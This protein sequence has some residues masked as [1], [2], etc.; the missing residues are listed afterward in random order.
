[1]AEVRETD[2]PAPPPE[3]PKRARVGLWTVLGT[4]IIFS[5]VVLTGLSLTGRTLI[6]PDWVR[7]EIETRINA[8][9]PQG[10]VR[11]GAVELAVSPQG[12]AEVVLRDIAVG[13][14]TGARLADLNAVRT[15]LPLAGL[16]Q[17]DVTP[18]AIALRGAQITV[19]R[20]VE[21]QF[22]LSYG[23]GAAPA[24]RDLAGI[25]DALEATLA[26]PSL[27]EI[28]EFGA[29]DL[30]ITLEDARTGQLWQA[31]NAALRLGRNPDGLSI[32]V[33]SEL[34]NGTD[35]LAELQFSVRSFTETSAADL[36]VQVRDVAAADI[37]AQAPA[38]TYLS[39]LDA[40]VSGSIR[41][42][43]DADGMLDTFAA[44]LEIG[45]G[46]LRPDADAAA[47]PFDAGRA[48][49]TYAPAEQRITFSE[50]SFRS[51]TLAV[52]AEGHALLGEFDGPWPA[53]LTGQ[54][55]LQDMRL[56][57]EG[58]FDAPVSVEDASADF[59]LR[60]DPFGVELG[61]LTARVG[62]GL[63]TATG[64]AG[65][66]GGGWD[67]ALDA[68]I[69]RVDQAAVLA[70]WPVTLTPETRGWLKRNLSQGTLSNVEGAVRVADTAP[71]IFGLSFDFEGAALRYLP[72]MPILEGAA[73][74]ASFHDKRF[75]ISVTDGFTQ[76]RQGR[77][78]IG[79]S[80]FTIPDSD[81]TPS[82]IELDVAAKGAA[83]AALDL[84]SN[85]PIGIL[86][87]LPFGPGDIAGGIDAT[88]SLSLLSG[89]DPTFEELGLSAT[90]R[91][92]DVESAAVAPG[93][94]LASDVLDLTVDADGLVID[95][96]LT[97]DGVPARATLRRSLGPGTQTAAARIDGDVTVTPETLGALSVDL[98]DGTVSGRTQA[99]FEI[100]LPQAGP[101][102]MRVASDLVGLGLAIPPA[103]WAKPDPVRGAFEAIVTLEEA[104][105]ITAL[106]LSAPGLSA[107]NI[108]LSLTED[109]DLASVTIPR[110]RLEDWLD[111]SVTVTPRGPGQIPAL[112]IDGG[113]LDIRGLASQ[114]GTGGA[115]NGAGPVVLNPDRVVISDGITL[116]DFSGQ[117][118]PGSGISGQ[119]TAR[120]NG[121]TAIQG[122]VIP[123][124]N[125]TAIRIQ[126]GDAGGAIRDAGFLKNGAGG[127]LDLIL[128]PNGSPGSYDGEM[129]MENVT[130]RDAPALAALLDGISI[131][132]LLDD[133]GT[134]I[135]FNTVDARFLLT[136]SQLRLRRSAAVGA[137]MGISMDGIYDLAS[138]RIDM[139]GV[140]SPI[141]VL[142][143]IGSIFTR[144]GEGL[145]G[146]NFRM[147][148]DARAPRIAINPLSILTP[149]MFREIFRRPPPRIDGAAPSQ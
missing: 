54:L 12:R 26:A 9:L 44:T 42:T 107:E 24:A 88:A 61:R 126:S 56:A 3:P 146:F 102:R 36:G 51:D 45:Q 140:I 41:T 113:R 92:S 40:A 5:L 112:R 86:D 78:D 79:G 77:L 46:A 134:G 125:G 122:G 55:A 28:T 49:L 14:P 72:D 69:D 128:S 132:G 27:A 90:A 58:V 103:G 59:R 32:T 116:T 19:R 144:R 129:L 147:T 29:D 105:E 123:V 68:G 120:V 99:T 137:S 43:L 100:E 135:Q 75:V 17:G 25:I 16:L 11:L 98:P 73:G 115:A 64:R 71:P 35:T 130:V 109:R 148:G 89:K 95:G 15:R 118:R 82:T 149:G 141:Y 76:T 34:F 1:M 145:F 111:A 121:G 57:P 136:P 80:V 93:R 33:V 91:L 48:F 139:Q 60:L 127:S 52:S 87:D 66:G 38:L 6:A 124:N 65:V 131:V 83:A 4:L 110:L 143:G 104:P 101:P 114:S 84:L 7:A 22:T 119:F 81:A 96:E 2:D 20:D 21:G 37:A 117:L 30:T 63:L 138:D 39:L 50:L 142:N 108:R 85:P 10:S 74:R 31:S 133:G 97:I 8:G 62:G 94:V 67:V 106:S 70:N 47:V 18:T 23:G 13:D 53:S